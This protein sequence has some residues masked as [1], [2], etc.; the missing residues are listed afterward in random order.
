[1]AHQRLSTKWTLYYHD[2]ET[3]DWSNESYLKVTEMITPQE[4]WSVYDILPKHSF[5]LGMFFLMRDDIFPTWEDDDNKN[6]GCWS[7]KVSVADIAPLWEILSARLVCESL[8]TTGE[9]R[10]LI[11]GISISPKKGFC[12][13]KIWNRNSALSNSNLLK[14][15]IPKLHHNE[16]LYVAF[17]DKD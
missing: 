16:S 3:N 7:Y 12:V 1:M 13:L 10:T 9:D 14:N 5:H 2:P 6:G 8:T 17:R 15:D 11:N 4:F